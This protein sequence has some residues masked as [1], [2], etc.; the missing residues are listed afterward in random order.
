MSWI[1]LLFAHWAVPPH[2]LAPWIVA[3][4]ELHTF[5]GSAWLGVVPFRMENVGP[6]GVALP[7]VVS[8]FPEINVRTYVTHRDKPGV[9]FFSLDATSR[10]AVVLGRTIFRLPYFLAHIEIRR[11]DDCTHYHSRRILDGGEFAAVFRTCEPLSARPG[12][13]DEWLT[14]RYCLYS[15]TPGRLIRTE[16]QH[17]R[18]PLHR[19]EAT[20]RMNTLATRLGCELG[21]TPDLL[22]AAP[23]LDVIS[24]LP[25]RI[26]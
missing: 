16:V 22:H 12:S 18:W 23:R 1:D 11:D 26:A 10:L 24:W 19:A 5:D 3:P 7:R 13:I 17:S 21:T 6:R 15:G 2:V 25:E 14:E 9:W 4:L 8:A 20:V